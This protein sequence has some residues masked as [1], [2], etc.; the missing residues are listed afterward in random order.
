MA[1]PINR[2]YDRV[3]VYFSCQYVAH[4]T[5]EKLLALAKEAKLKEK[6]NSRY[7]SMEN[8]FGL[9][10]L[11]LFKTSHS[12]SICPYAPFALLYNL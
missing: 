2:E 7:C 8:M 12:Y 9:N 1:T 5:L 6:I 11:S 4:E 10:D 3:L